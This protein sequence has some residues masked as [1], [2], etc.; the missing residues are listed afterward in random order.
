MKLA[1]FRETFDGFDPLSGA[2]YRQSQTRAYQTTIDD[3]AACAANPDAASFFGA[4]ETEIVA[5]NLQR[6]TIGL[7]L[8]FVILTIN[9]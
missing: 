7:D 2:T 3:D 9:L 4:G 6:Q 5:Q 8:D 1:I